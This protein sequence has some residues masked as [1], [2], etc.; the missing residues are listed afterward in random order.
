MIFNMNAGQG[1]KRPILDDAYPQDCVVVAGEMA[2]FTVM[3]AQDGKPAE[4]TYQWYVNGEAAEDGIGR[5]YL[6]STASDGGVCSVYCVVT[7]PAGTVT[8]RVAKLTILRN[9]TVNTNPGATVTAVAGAETVSATADGT[10]IATL[11]LADG[12]W[13]VT[14]T[15]GVYTKSSRVTISADSES[16]T[17]KLILVQYLYNRGDLCSEES[18]GWNSVFQ[19]KTIGNSYTS[20]AQRA[21][22]SDNIYTYHYRKADDYGNW[23]FYFTGKEIDFSGF[24]TL[25]IVANGDSKFCG[26]GVS[27]T[28]DTSGKIATTATKDGLD[29]YQLDISAISSGYVFFGTSSTLVFDGSAGANGSSGTMYTYEIYLT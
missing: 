11:P 1:K 29:T 4:Y 18:G 12:V 27:S 9:L 21:V 10:G 26:V 6:R 13:T 2:S 5:N 17:L 25:Y 15:D 23:A 24:K 16:H 28:A 7:S 3:I 20:N 22:N 19:S 14:A 8:S